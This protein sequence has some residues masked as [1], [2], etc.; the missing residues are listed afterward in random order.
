MC[1]AVYNGFAVTANIEDI[2]LHQKKFTTG[3]QHNFRIAQ[4]LMALQQPSVAFPEVLQQCVVELA[5][6]PVM[7]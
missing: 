6:A 5:A 7:E 1:F 4:V 2:I 3:K